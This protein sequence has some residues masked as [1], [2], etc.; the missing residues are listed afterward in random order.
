MS[1]TILSDKHSLNDWLDFISR[2]HPHEIDLGLER[3]RQ[4]Y[5]RLSLPYQSSAYTIVVSGTNGK[6]S[7]I[8]M[9]E[10]CLLSLGYSVGTYTSPHISVYNE[11]VRVNGEQ[12]SDESLVH[13]FAEV[14]SVRKDIALTYF[15]Y[16][17]LAA[18]QCLFTKP[19]DVVLLEIGLGGRLDAVNVVDGDLAIITSIGIDHVDWLGDDLGQIAREKAGIIRAEKPVLLGENLPVEAAQVA[20]YLGAPCLTCGSDFGV[21]GT[22]VLL[23]RGAEQIKFEFSQSSTLPRNNIAL[24]MQAIECFTGGCL[25][26]VQWRE[27]N[28]KVAL[29]RVP[30]RLEKVRG[31]DQ[32]ILDV[33][34]NPHAAEFLASHLQALGQPGRKV[35]AVY[36]S[37]EDKDVLGVVQ[38]MK[39]QVDE[40]FIA[41]LDVPRAMSLEKLSAEV[42]KVSQ[43]VLS[44][45]TLQDAIRHALP[46]SVDDNTLV[47]IFGSFYVVEAAK[48]YFES[49]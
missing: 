38:A 11:R 22:Q 14:E 32:V 49:L 30:G 46:K 40:W 48:A 25:S 29:L 3:V 36:S 17:T 45:A 24:A 12:I 7:T 35:R 26:D 34:H 16:G 19:L 41:A 18:F 39:G 20:Q 5:E 6:G 27:C 37:L 33:G 28:N 42:G 23:R 13:A 1:K 31:V 47:L 21:E 8:A 44:F 4:V 9:I 2:S 43:S 10:Q 15:E